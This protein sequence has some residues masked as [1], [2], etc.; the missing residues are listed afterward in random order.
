[1]KTYSYSLLLLLLVNT[2]G[3][4]KS[5]LSPLI[6]FDKK[7]AQLDTVIID[8]L[9][10]DDLIIRS[11]EDDLDSINVDYLVVNY[12]EI[13]ESKYSLSNKTMRIDNFEIKSPKKV[14]TDSLNST[15]PSTEN[16]K[17]FSGTKIKKITIDKV[18]IPSSILNDSVTTAGKFEKFEKKILVKHVHVTKVHCGKKITPKL[19]RV[20]TDELKLSLEIIN[21]RLEKLKEM[22][23]NFVKN[24]PN[25]S[26]RTLINDNTLDK[27]QKR[28]NE[29]KAFLNGQRE[30]ITLGS[31]ERKNG[32]I[33][34]HHLI[35][36]DI[37]AQIESP[38]LISSCINNSVLFESGHYK[39]NQYLS[40]TEIDREIN[41]ISKEL[42]KKHIDNPKNKLK[43]Y[44]TVIGYADE[45]EIGEKLENELLAY[46]GKS[47]VYS[48]VYKQ[49]YLNLILSNERAKSI[50]FYIK[51]EVIKRTGYSSYFY[52]A[53]TSDGSYDFEGKGWEI[54][55]GISRNC[56]GDCASRRISCISN[57]SIIESIN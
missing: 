12:S 20:Q 3:C 21:D 43:V 49:K 42:S 15:K 53:T 10:I 6:S 23:K 29:I 19:I 34:D 50:F 24:N 14:Y 47:K 22:V 36:D 31:I 25:S 33:M 16:M 11:Y 13:K 51:N 38:Q 1:M 56:T 8:N 4:V 26:P 44:L 30:E 55:K 48:G 17:V 5:L 54:P 40:L 7:L 46:S 39:I 57:F 9:Y 35:F 52:F 18:Y 2:E 41:K 28:F 27:Y 37:E 45:E 32:I